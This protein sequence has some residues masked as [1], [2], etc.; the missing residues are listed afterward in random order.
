M[1]RSAR[2]NIRRLAVGRLISLTGGAAAY[3]ALMFTIWHRTHSAGLQSLALLLTFGVSG[4]IGPVTGS[5]GDRFDRRKVMIWSEAVSAVIF[6][7]MAFVSA[8]ILLIALA[9]A[10]A[11][12]DTP[13]FSAS[14]AAIPN[15]AE[16]EEDITW[17]NSLISIGVHAG[18][19]IG[20]VAGGLL[21]AVAGPSWVFA[22]NAISF[23]LSVVL[24]VSVRG[25]YTNPLREGQEEHTGVMAGA[26][27]IVRDRL[28]RLVTLAWLVFV[29]GMG[30]GMV[31]DAPLA[32]AFRAGSVGFG[33]M[34]ACWGSGS[35]LGAL[36]GRRL[37]ARTEPLAILMGCAG[38]GVAGLAIGF[39]PTFLLVLA[40]LLA[41]GTC[42]GLQ[43]VAEQG[44]MQRRSPDAVRSRVLAASDGVVSMGLAVAYLLAGPALH[45]LGPKLVYAVGGV[46]ALAAGAVLLP[47]LRS[48]EEVV[49]AEDLIE[50]DGAL[51]LRVTP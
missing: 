50:T 8:P 26:R 19:A 48:R 25:S 12:A 24:T 23:A 10:S 35:V 27:F 37:T 46:A 9:F 42:D 18:I 38:V 36:A 21:L 49:V 30:M 33:L 47:L 16:R 6:A 29:L 43:M 7:V 1:S 32:E 22:I 28:L 15:L 44:L 20:P 5:L 40:A 41:M 3:T 34:I 11:V 14:R 17:A 31:A 13:F 2:A 4:I 39:S 45:A 51:E